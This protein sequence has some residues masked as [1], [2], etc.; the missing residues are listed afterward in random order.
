MDWFLVIAIIS[1]F[2]LI[3]LTCSHWP[4]AGPENTILANPIQEF[5]GGAG[6]VSRD[7]EHLFHHYK[8]KFRKTYTSEKEMEHR[9]HTF[10]HNMR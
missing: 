8:K 10:I 6:D 9:K 4:G 5:V 2:R 7:H 3:D 1:V